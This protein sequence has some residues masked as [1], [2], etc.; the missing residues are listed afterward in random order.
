MER[1]G[2]TETWADSYPNSSETGVALIIAFA[3][4]G[5]M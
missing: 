5:S 3:A 2:T 1:R 4:N